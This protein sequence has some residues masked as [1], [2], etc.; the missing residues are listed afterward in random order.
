MAAIWGKNKLVFR[1]PL[2]PLYVTS[3]EVIV[4]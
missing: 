2:D 4:W 3:V 1:I